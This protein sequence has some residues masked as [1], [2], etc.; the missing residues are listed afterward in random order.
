MIKFLKKLLKKRKLLKKY[1]KTDRHY[2][3]Q[4]HLMSNFNWNDE[5]LHYFEHTF[6]CELRCYRRIKKLK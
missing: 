3:D 4:I 5:Q 1:N 2:V 6:N